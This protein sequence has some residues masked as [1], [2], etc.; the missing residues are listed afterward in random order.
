M[1][2]R[3][4]INNTGMEVY[5]ANVLVA[6]FGSTVTVG[7]VTAGKS[8][9][10]ID[11][12]GNLYLRNNTTPVISLLSTGVGEFVGVI[13]ASGGTFT[14]DVTA[15]SVT[16]GTSGISGVN[17]DLTATGL[18]ATNADISGD[19]TATSIGADSGSI[20]GWLVGSNELSSSGGHVLFSSQGHKISVGGGNASHLIGS[21]GFQVEYGGQAF[22]FSVDSIQV[23]MQMVQ[24]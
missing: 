19:I 24:S 12:S 14:G 7:Q 8:N 20:G 10:H 13:S 16:M 6:D 22:V 3:V 18:V 23:C 1:G 2:D 4:V 9:V 17:F 11:A 15:G 5:E 21:D